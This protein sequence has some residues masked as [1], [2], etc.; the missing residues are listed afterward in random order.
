MSSNRVIYTPIGIIHSEHRFREKTPIQPKYAQECVGQAEIFPE[1]VDGL[2]DIEAFSHIY[3]LFHIHQADP[4]Q[5]IVKPFLQ[6][7]AHGV[8]ATRA[9]CRPNP[10]GISIVELIR[11]EGNILHLK[12]LDILDG[13]PLLDIKPYTRRFDCVTTTRNGWQDA[14]D[15]ETAAR[16]GKRAYNDSRGN[17][18]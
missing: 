6:D 13:T 18:P 14:I 5:L 17:K 3:L 8:F 9:P 16:L 7:E 4:A 10:I 2:R 15:E 1:F 12:G 11:R